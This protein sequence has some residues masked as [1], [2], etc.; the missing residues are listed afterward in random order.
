M[1]F[2][3]LS[4]DIQ[5]H[6]QKYA[7]RTQRINGYYVVTD[8]ATNKTIVRLRI[9][10]DYP[11]TF[12]VH[13]ESG[14]I[15]CGYGP[16]KAGKDEEF[17][18]LRL[19]SDG[20]ITIQRDL[21]CTL[22]LF[23]GYD[24][25]TFTV[26]NNFHSAWD[27]L[28]KHTLDKAALAE[29]LLPDLSWRR[30]TSCMEIHTLNEL[31]KLNFRNGKLKLS[32]GPARTWMASRDAPPSNPHD[33][34][35]VLEKHADVTIERF[36]KYFDAAVFELSGGLDSSFLPLYISQ[37]HPGAVKRASSMLLTGHF[38]ET[39]AE[40]LGALDQR[41]HP[42]WFYVSFDDPACRPMQD[43]VTTRKFAVRNYWAPG[44]EEL[45]EHYASQ[46]SAKG[47]RI[48]FTGDGGDE[49]F[50]NM[51]DIED[52]LGLG[53][54]ASERRLSE[55][56][57]PFH[58][59]IFRSAWR[60]A[61]LQAKFMNYPQLAVNV[62]RAL[63]LR[64]VFIEHGIWPIS[65]FINKELYYFCQGLPIR[66]RANKNIFRAYSQAKRLPAC[67]YNPR[68]DEHPGNFLDELYLSGYYNEL[69]DYFCTHGMVVNHF[70]YI[71]K[72][73]LLKTLLGC[74]SGTL[75]AEERSKAIFLTHLWLQAEIGLTQF[76]ET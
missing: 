38:R 31:E 49:L 56:L 57:T 73:V 11:G 53:K 40:K 34:I 13:E 14:A 62:H 42:E 19:A 52:S 75:K 9:R 51:T 55:S 18:H 10:D 68:A 60:T 16:Q 76:K 64:N 32:P 65:P 30:Q 59:E 4:W 28:T 29:W 46:L 50:D 63:P 44:F 24:G 43:A 37:K 27:T 71:D 47:C 8:V 22:A 72:N 67:I 48:I 2:L 6:N 36:G 3:H 15:F 69:I 25:S 35:S 21:L 1:A 33:F 58:T 26:S 23:Y 54:A 45:L 39:Q 70:G 5:H 61:A 20:S 12:C 41:I 7:Y 66:Y 17:L 74:F